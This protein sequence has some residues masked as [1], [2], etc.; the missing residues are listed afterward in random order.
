[1]ATAETFDVLTDRRPAEDVEATHPLATSG[2]RRDSKVCT[3]RGFLF[4]CLFVFVF[5]TLWDD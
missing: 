4:V 1:M 3:L 5:G 2:Q